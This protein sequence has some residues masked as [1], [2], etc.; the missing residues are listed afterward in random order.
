MRG[1]K[2][3]TSCAVASAVMLAGTPGPVLAWGSTGHRL[4]GRAAVKALPPEI[5]PFLRSPRAVIEIG[6]LSREPD[7]SKDSGRT[8]DADRDAGHFLDLGDDG[9]V[10]GGPL[11]TALPAT[12]QEYETVLR[13]A[14][15]DNWKAGYLPYSIIECWQQLAKDLAMWRT[16]VAGA[17]HAHGA[18]RKAWFET[19][20]IRRERLVFSDLGALSHFVGDGSQ[21]LH[22]T[23][24]FNGWGSFPNPNG[25]TQDKVH[26]PFEGDLVRRTVTLAA[27]S[28]A[29]A[30]YRDCH[31]PIDQ[32]V[33]AYL[34][35]TGQQ[36]IPFY[37]MYKAGGMA[38]GR[39]EG[40]KF[41]TERLAV[42]ASELRDLIVEAWK[43]SAS[44]KVGWPQISVADVEAGKVDPYDS[45][46]GLD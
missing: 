39:P 21:P 16:D 40:T 34:T 23:D 35:A 2:T 38:P 11:L 10:F 3:F 42:G 4:V 26:G 43:A 14:G 28:A 32:R 20:R 27:V 29:M 12:R 37:E 41:A 17:R 22:V 8:H 5:P 15:A 31:C 6:E 18:A 30:T 33:G 1:W 44:G 36:V 25:Y 19:D 46:M 7:R 13:A 45:L 9:R 24:H